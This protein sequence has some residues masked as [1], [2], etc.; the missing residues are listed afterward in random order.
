[1]DNNILKAYQEKLAAGLKS[2]NL[3]IDDIESFMGEAIE[4]FKN[5]LAA[6]TKQVIDETDSAAILNECPDCGRGLKKTKLKPSR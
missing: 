1:M 2:R 6:S 4:Q 3:S 5:D